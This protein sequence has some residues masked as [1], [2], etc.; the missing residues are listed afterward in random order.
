MLPKLHIHG[1]EI[2]QNEAPIADLDRD[3]FSLP[4]FNAKGAG[5]PHFEHAVKG[6]RVHIRFY[7]LPSASISQSQGNQG[8]ASAGDNRVVVLYRRHSNSSR[9]GTSKMSGIR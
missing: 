7:P 6:S 2:H 8:R 3:S 9:L 4:P 5:K 1:V